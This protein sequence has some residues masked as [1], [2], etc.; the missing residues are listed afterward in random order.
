MPRRT[1]QQAH[2]GIGEF[3]HQLLAG[4]GRWLSFVM[5]M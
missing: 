2:K 5:Q 3:E 1:Q 4:H